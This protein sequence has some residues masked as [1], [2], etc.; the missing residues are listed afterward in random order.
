M[1]AGR[2]DT[3]LAPRAT[4]PTRAQPQQE[5]QGSLTRV[6]FRLWDRHHLSVAQTRLSMQG[7]GRS[8]HAGASSELPATSGGTGT[9]GLGHG[10]TGTP[11]G[12]STCVYGDAQA[13]MGTQGPPPR[14][15]ID[16][17]PG[18]TQT[19]VPGRRGPPLRGWRDDCHG[20]AQ[21]S[22]TGIQVS[23]LSSKSAVIPGDTWTTSTGMNEPLSC[24]WMDNKTTGTTTLDTVTRTGRDESLWEAGSKDQGGGA[25]GTFPQ[26]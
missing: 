8:G 4:R 15:C 25:M 12:D 3:Q 1:P 16:H 7:W 14:G 24:R 5:P 19:A 18:N 20:N 6:E 9:H 26:L 22:G 2:W 23:A 13:I 21:A 11:D 17:G 10:D